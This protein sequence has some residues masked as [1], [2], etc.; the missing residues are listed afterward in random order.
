MAAYEMF[1]T[2]DSHS[3]RDHT[4]GHVWPNFASKG[5]VGVF[6]ESVGDRE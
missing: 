1:A 2:W 4:Q 3:G 6:L 5:V